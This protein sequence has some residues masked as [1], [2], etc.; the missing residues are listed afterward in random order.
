[1]VDVVLARDVGLCVRLS[2]PRTGRTP[3]APAPRAHRR[4]R[5]TSATATEV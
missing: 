2:Q 5:A 1:M 4:G 3:D